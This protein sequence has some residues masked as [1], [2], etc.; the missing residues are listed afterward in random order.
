MA[1]ENNV[2]NILTLYDPRSL[3][4]ENVLDCRLPSVLKKMLKWF[5]LLTKPPGGSVLP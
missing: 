5:R 1:I 2:P 3:S 4:V